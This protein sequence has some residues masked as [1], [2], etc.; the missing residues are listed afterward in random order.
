MDGQII[1]VL[2]APPPPPCPTIKFILL[3]SS[4]LTS[5]VLQGRPSNY[6]HHF[7]LTMFLFSLN[8]FFLFFVVLF[9]FLF[10]FYGSIVD[11]QY[12]SFRWTKKWFSFI[13]IIFHIIFPCRLL[14][15]IEY[16]SLCYTV[17]PYSLFVLHYI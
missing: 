13:Y 1:N 16:S 7:L 3:I 10:I 6:K 9:C 8:S 17:G 12:I 4:P 11:L 2:P 15:N 14:E 5:I